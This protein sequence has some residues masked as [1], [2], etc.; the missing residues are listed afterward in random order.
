VVY[1]FTS[2]FSFLVFINHDD[3]PLEHIW[4]LKVCET[5][6]PTS[7]FG[8]MKKVILKQSY[9]YML[10]QPLNSLTSRKKN[11]KQHKCQKFPGG[12]VV[13]ALQ[14]HCQGPGS[15]AG[16]GTTQAAWH[17]QKTP[18]TKKQHKCLRINLCWK[19]M[20]SNRVL[21]IWNVACEI[22]VSILALLFTSSVTLKIFL[23]F[24]I[25]SL[26]SEMELRILLICCDSLNKTLY[27]KH[28]AWCPSLWLL[29][30]RWFI[31]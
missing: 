11:L 16:R 17:G 4:C 7:I 31:I 12:P 3:F 22:R 18:K 6:L 25:C 1:I 2:L 10:L 14:F 19:I 15:N 13:I 8:S 23:T 28:L 30:K 24:N 27:V 26:T 20:R 9:A 21:E 29:E 5:S